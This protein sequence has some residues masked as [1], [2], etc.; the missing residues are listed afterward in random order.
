MN[1]LIFNLNYKLFDIRYWILD[2]FEYFCLL[3][4]IEESANI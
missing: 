3:I 2:N 4:T 1:S